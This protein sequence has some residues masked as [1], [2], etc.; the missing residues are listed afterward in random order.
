MVSRL[1]RDHSNITTK[2][3]N[4]P[5][6][7]LH[8]T[9]PP[10][11]EGPKPFLNSSRYLQTPICVLLH[12]YCTTTVLLLYHYCTT[13]VLLLYYYFTTTVLLLYYSCTTTVLLLYYYC[14]TPVLLL[15]YYSTTT[16]LLYYY[17]TTTALLLYYYCT[18]A[19]LL[20]YYYCNTTALLL[21]YYC[22]ITDQFLGGLNNAFF[23]GGWAFLGR[24]APVCYWSILRQP[25][26]LLYYYCT[27]VQYQ[28]SDLVDCGGECRL[29][30]KVLKMKEF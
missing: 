9:L 14:T 16:L 23:F 22:A 17:C 24:V 29:E 12:D 20:L 8:P 4:P 10:Q 15:Y 28:A 7:L 5:F 11:F 27:T 19:V 3:E 18:T 25:R 21:Y 26:L 13:T 2:T 6:C 30:E 1:A